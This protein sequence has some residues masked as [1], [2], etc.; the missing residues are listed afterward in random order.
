MSD[1]SAEHEFDLL[2]EQIATVLADDDFSAALRFGHEACRIA[3]ERNGDSDPLHA[4]A[5]YT[6]ASI[7]HAVSDYAAAGSCLREATRI[8][9]ENSGFS[10]VDRADFGFDLAYFHRML[11]ESD[12][13]RRLFRQTIDLCAAAGNP[14]RRLEAS[15]YHLLAELAEEDGNYKEAERLHHQGMTRRERQFGKPSLLYRTSLD[16]LLQNYKK[17]NRH[18]LIGPLLQEVHAIYV[19]NDMMRHPYYADKLDEMGRHHLAEGDL[20]LARKCLQG[21]LEIRGRL[22]GRDTPHYALSLHNLAELTV[23]SGQ[24]D[25]ALGMIRQGL[26]I[27]DG[28]LG[29]GIVGRDEHRF[30]AYLRLFYASL[31][32]L[33]S[34]V[35]DHLGGDR[36]AVRTA[37]EFVL[38]RKAIGIEAMA[39]R[40]KFVDEASN[41]EVY[42]RYEEVKAVQREINRIA[43]LSPGAVIERR[44]SLKTLKERKERLEEELS[45]IVS[46]LELLER[47][48]E[49]D[50]GM[51][52]KELPDKGVLVEFVRFHTYHFGASA[53][54]GAPS[55]RAPRFLAFVLPEK[56]PDELALI[57]LGDGDTIDALIADFRGQV[58]ENAGER[59]D[60]DL[61]KLSRGPRKT[62]NPEPGRAL[63]DTIFRPLLGAVG[64]SRRLVLA[65]DGDLSLLPFE[66]LPLDDG[67]HIIDEY[68]IS[69]VTVGR[70]ILRVA[71]RSS[72]E[73]TASV[74]I[75]DPDFDL[76]RG[77]DVE[78]IHSGAPGSVASRL[79]ETSNR[80]RDLNLGSESFH[81][82][83]GTQIEGEKVGTLLGVTPWTAGDADVGRLKTQRSP[84]ILH[85]ATHGFFLEDVNTTLA[86]DE[87]MLGALPWLSREALK[88]RK[89]LFA[90]S[91]LML[92]IGL[93]QLFRRFRTTLNLQ[94]DLEEELPE[95]RRQMVGI[96]SLTESDLE[97]PLLRSGLALAGANRRRT[98]SDSSSEDDGL[99]TAADVT[100]MDL[101]G[102]ELV[103]LSACGSGLG[104]VRLGE[105]VF[106]LRRAFS[107]AGADTLVMSLWKVDDLATAVLMERF[108][109]NLLVRGLARAEALREAQIHLRDLTVAQIRETWLSPELIDR[110]AAGNHAVRLS[111]NQMAHQADDVRPFRSP[112]YWGAFIC[113]GQPGPLPKAHS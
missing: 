70:D 111:L 14:C 48:R 11:G 61:L 25:R 22:F 74:V 47:M 60:R 52:A 29:R 40:R 94:L 90:T 36:E 95:V 16:L 107:L 3:R 56:C 55:W 63:Y 86:P 113:Q 42:E 102:T 34:L 8:W 71:D 26:A 100:G 109:A 20:S 49:A 68:D 77:S 24:A 17:S 108:Y 103:V 12:D 110:L 9:E 81:R 2:A 99:L 85:V 18:E 57:D 92:G 83:P 51:I 104:E 59:D 44:K 93:L 1:A 91:M 64:S 7:H 45:E 15:S 41:P 23:V 97:N 73:S 89:D 75:A 50:P 39:A 43:L 88:S 87:V 13:A 30:M 78:S 112:Y 5:N 69:Y 35:A 101:S 21:S 82:L 53:S 10:P 38:K 105:G 62:S 80:S 28:L 6:L 65:P 79:A 66:T 67:R 46:E 54:R 37:L 76:T 32:R 31:C 72:T 58:V 33:L 106:G 98:G 96:D 19:V 84:S 27:E 4:E